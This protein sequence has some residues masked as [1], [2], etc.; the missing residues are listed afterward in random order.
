L[1]KMPE[2]YEEKN[3]EKDK[4]EELSEDEEDEK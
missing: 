2:V 3:V 4:E 1:T